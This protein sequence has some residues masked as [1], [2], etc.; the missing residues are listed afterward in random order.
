MVVLLASF[1]NPLS[2]QSV[3]QSVSL[4]SYAFIVKIKF[5]TVV[6]QYCIIM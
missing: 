2:A 6:V 3:N 1:L 5:M 4:T